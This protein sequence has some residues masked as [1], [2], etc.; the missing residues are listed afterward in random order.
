MPRK[1]NQEYKS[2]RSL[3]LPTRFVPVGDVVLIG[4]RTYRVVPNGARRPSDACLGCAF[5]N[6]WCPSV[7]CSSFDREDGIGV[8]FVRVDDDDD[9]VIDMED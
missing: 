8:W 7:A 4:E 2:E 1:A 3:A 5:S 9:D 6:G